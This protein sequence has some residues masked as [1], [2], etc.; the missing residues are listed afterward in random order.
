MADEADMASHH[1][2]LM[3]DLA[4]KR[5][6]NHAPDLPATGACHWC[7]AL[8][9]AGARF[10]DKDCLNDWERARRAACRA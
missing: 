9:P 8:V 5:A 3:R 7:D 6:A 10:C 1:E 4:M 2:E